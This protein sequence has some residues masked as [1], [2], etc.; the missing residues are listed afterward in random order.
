M[1]KRKKN[2]AD[3]SKLST[4]KIKMVHVLFTMHFSTLLHKKGISTTYEEKSRQRKK[5]QWILTFYLDCQKTNQP[6]NA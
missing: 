6:M 2:S 1:E 5:T 3:V 4:A